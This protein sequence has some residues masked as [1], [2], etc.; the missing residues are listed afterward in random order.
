MFFLAG[1]TTLLIFLV[2]FIF[3]FL[4]FLEEIYEYNK[5]KN[6]EKLTVLV[7]LY[8]KDYGNLQSGQ[9]FI[10]GIRNDFKTDVKKKFTLTEEMAVKTIE[11][12]ASE[13]IK[14]VAIGGGDLTKVL[15]VGVVV[16]VSLAFGEPNFI[17]G[18]F[19]KEVALF[20]LVLFVCN[21]KH[22]KRF[23]ES[24]DQ[25]SILPDRVRTHKIQQSPF[26]RH[27]LSFV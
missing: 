19:R 2:L 16:T 14:Q 8:N 21:Y 15:T 6:D 18:D 3:K 26:F 4:Y 9:K 1:K 27:R 10:E 20:L 12:T 17:L 7:D 13:A 22:V 24:W 5:A 23:S 11:D 25:T